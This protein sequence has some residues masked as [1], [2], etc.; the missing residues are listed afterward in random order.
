MIFNKEWLDEWVDN[1]LGAE[2]LSDLITMAG[3]EVDS[4]R[5]VC[6]E[7][8]KVVVGEV[9]SCRAHENSDHLHVTEVDVGGAQPLQVVCG[10]PNCRAGLKVACALVGAKLPGGV[11]IKPSRLRGVDSEGML[12]SYR[13]LGL[14]EDGSGIMELPKDARVGEDLHDCLGLDDV[15][16][17]VDLTTNRPD[18][19]GLRGVA[20]EV[21]VLLGKDLH[22]PEVAAVAE[23][24]PD[25]V[26]VTVEAWKSCPRYLSRVIRGVNQ[27]AASPLWMT[28]R[29]RRCG[30]RPV[31]PIVDVTNYVMLELSQPMHSFDLDRVGGS[32]VVRNARSGERLTLLSGEEIALD[33]DTL[34]IA[35]RDR[36]IALAG[37]FGGQDSGIGDSTC[38]VL[39]ESAFFAPDAIKGR[40]RRYGLDTD[41]SHRFERGVDFMGQRRA[42][43]RATELLLAIGGGVA[44]PIREAV[45]EG[46]LPVRHEIALRMSKLT[47]VLGTDIA[48]GEVGDILRRLGLCP[49]E[50]PEGFMAVAPSFRFDLEIEEDLIEEVARIHGYHKIPNLV[51]VSELR[52]VPRPEARLREP[53]LRDALLARGYQEAITYSFTDPKVLEALSP[54]RPLLLT[55]PI[56]PELSAMRTTILGGL[57]GALRYNLNRQQRRVRLFEEGL[58]YIR[59]AGAENGVRQEAMLG[60]VATG[61][62]A[63]E[64]W[65]I[66]ARP[67][68][69]F[70]L[71]G[72]VES[73]LL[74]TG[75]PGAFA[76]RPT[77]TPC[78]H[79]TQGADIY[80]GDRLVGCVGMLH[81]K[82]ERELGLKQHVGVF[83]LCHGAI[84]ERAVPVAA[85][86]SKFPSIRRDFAFVLGKGVAASDFVAALRE[87]GGSLV[88]DAR[89]FDVF[90][91]DSLGDSRSVAVGV[92][93]QDQGRTLEDAAVEEVA[94]R[95][96]AAARE[97]FGAQLR[98]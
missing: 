27:R 63:D 8:T 47:R 84:T 83:E 20:R 95:I 91:D 25:A 75:R 60:G 4:V 21:A 57:I 33:P 93:L 76:F 56:S 69:F 31:S 59:D 66:P 64:N 18:C 9:R 12:C 65:A 97:R 39:L 5:P 6:G 19:L 58:V 45:D 87:A 73:L 80:L 30:V 14:S 41:A 81:P 74:L 1:Q 40:A 28:E 62:A 26:E 46:S 61:S 71:K 49:R 70:D 34:V 48:K 52:S 22:E 35:D 50:T 51:P 68:D 29:L 7:F 55:S 85:P 78:L 36:P 77:A 98:Q 54:E 44:G 96:V 10:A 67:L 3:L 42:M 17:D 37:I 53:R 43:E 72:D 94:G 90:S 24:C 32:I 86:V 2:E 38:N 89:V 92:I 23:G 82:V 13:E 88:V 16:I 79:P 11:E 15:A